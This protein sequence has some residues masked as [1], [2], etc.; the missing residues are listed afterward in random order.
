MAG[1]TEGFPEQCDNRWSI[2][3][4]QLERKPLVPLGLWVLPFT[5]HFPKRSLPLGINIKVY[6]EDL[7]KCVPKTHSGCCP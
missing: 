2:H 7:R 6:A 3:P 1:S 4:E 5:V